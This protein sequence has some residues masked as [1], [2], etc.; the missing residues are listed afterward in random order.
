M[1]RQNITKRLKTEVH[2]AITAIGGDAYSKLLTMHETGLRQHCNGFRAAVYDLSNKPTDSKLK[3]KVLELAHT[4]EDWGSSFDYHLVTTIVTNADQIIK[5]KENLTADNVE[6]L[7]NHA[8][9]LSWYQLRKCLV[10]VVGLGT[11]C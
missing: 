3:T 1:K 9:L 5:D 11:Y 6:L 7:L 4:I 8:K 2:H 10:T